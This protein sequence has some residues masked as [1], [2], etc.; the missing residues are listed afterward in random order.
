MKTRKQTWQIKSQGVHDP[1]QTWW[2][3]HRDI[4]SLKEAKELFSK[5]SREDEV[6]LRLRR[7]KIVRVVTEEEEIEETP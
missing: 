2:T 3:I 5:E 4:S 1:N 6:A 7:L